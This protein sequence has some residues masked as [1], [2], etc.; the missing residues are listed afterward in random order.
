LKL[1]PF[2][3]LLALGA[4]PAVA[5]EMATLPGGTF[6]SVLPAAPDVKEVTLPAFRLDRRPVTNAEFAAFVQKEPRWRRDRVAALFADENYLRHWTAPDRPAKGSEQQP[7]TQVSWFA[8][9]AYCEARGLRLPTWH[10]W[11]FAAAADE[12]QRD[13]RQDPVWRQRI[14]DW[15]ARPGGVPLADVGRAPPNVYGVQ[16]LHGMVWEW[17]EDFGA[18]MVSG[19]NREQGD[20]DIMKFCGTGALSMEQKEHYAVLMRIAMLSSLQARYTTANLGFRCAGD[21]G[22]PP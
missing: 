14:L 7:V 22:A 5:A 2:L 4:G 21:A 12:R 8:A 10:E 17:V 15:Y 18:M 6:E 20:P 11:E 19:D 3:L 9:Q 13:A 16:D 1:R